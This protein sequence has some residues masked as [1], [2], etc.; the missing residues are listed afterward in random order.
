MEAKKSDS[1][2]N[3]NL[4]FPIMLMGVL[5]VSGILLASFT[6]EVGVISDINLS[7]E[8]ASDNSQVQTVDKPEEPEEQEEPPKVEATPPP[9]EEVVVEENTEEEP[10]A[11]VTPPPPMEIAVEEEP[12]PEAEIIDFPD[13]EAGF[14]GGAAEL[15]RWIV[16]NVQYPETSIEMEDQGRVYLSFVVEADGSISNIKVEKGVTR[17]LDREAKRLARKMPRWTP[18]EAGGRKVRTRGRLPIV[19]TLE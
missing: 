16:S 8:S 9:Q 15:H 2:N 4:R 18:G 11:V 10:V 12:L 6:Y 7:K 3:E 5:F 1:A 19:F 14:P 13:V 17:E